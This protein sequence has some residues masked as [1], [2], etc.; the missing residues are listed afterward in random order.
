MSK[1]EGCTYCYPQRENKIPLE[2]KPCPTCGYWLDLVQKASGDRNYLITPDGIHYTIEKE[3]DRGRADF[4][5]FG[6][7]AFRIEFSDGTKVRTTNLWHQG[8]VPQ[9]F[10]YLFTNVAVVME[11]M[12]ANMGEF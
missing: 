11:E 12:T 8:E 3:A 1:L 10:R 9:R 5:G 7:R 2:F 4:R 6:G